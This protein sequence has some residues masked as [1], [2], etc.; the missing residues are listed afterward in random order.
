MHPHQRCTATSCSLASRMAPRGTR[1]GRGDLHWQRRVEGAVPR[2]LALH[3]GR[4]RHRG[5][6]YSG[7]L[8]GLHAESNN[9]RWRLDVGGSGAAVAGGGTGSSVR[10]SAP[11]RPHSS[12]TVG[13]TDDCGA[14]MLARAQVWEW[15]SESEFAHR[16]VPTDAGLLVGAAAGTM[17]L[18][19]PTSGI[20]TWR[21]RPGYVS[22]I[23][24]PPGV[25]GRQAVAVTNQGNI[26]VSCAACGAPMPV[27]HLF[28]L[29]KASG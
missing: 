5:S 12:S 1:S 9:V 22:G 24:V 23:T 17:Y 18:V 2:Y 13:K 25:D 11:A 27:M 8:V 19:D 29:R 4:R 16:T 10:S 3:S 14:S 7:P 21:W 6:G 20:E 26:V 28:T 15:D